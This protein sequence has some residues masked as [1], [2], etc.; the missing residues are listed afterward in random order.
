MEPGGAAGI[1]RGEPGD[2]FGVVPGAAGLAGDERLGVAGAVGVGAAG[3][4]VACRGA[5]HRVGR[6]SPALVEGGGAGDLLGVAPGAVGLGDYV[7]LV[8]AGAVGVA[9]AGGAGAR[10]GARHRTDD[11]AA[12]GAGDFD[13]GVPPA[14]HLGGDEPVEVAG[15]VFVESA[16]GAV[17]R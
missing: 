3:G 1:E 4:A 6:G 13:G 11:A 8:V 7:G 5:R 15:A 10:R 17:A 2:L 9:A 16:G 14:V 12:G